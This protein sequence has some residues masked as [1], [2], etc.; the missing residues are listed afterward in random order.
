MLREMLVAIL[1]PEVPWGVGEDL[2]RIAA[3]IGVDV[4]LRLP[5]ESEARALKY[6]IDRAIF[7]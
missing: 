1:F 2:A 5:T 3:A 6:E 7:M 4:A